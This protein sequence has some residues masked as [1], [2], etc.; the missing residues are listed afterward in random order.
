MKR[1]SELLRKFHGKSVKPPGGSMSVAGWMMCHRYVE[2]NAKVFYF[3]LFLSVSSLI[4]NSLY[5]C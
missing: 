5:H 3:N 2:R 1:T 4:S